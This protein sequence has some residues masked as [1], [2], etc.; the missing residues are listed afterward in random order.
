MEALIDVIEDLKL[1]RKPINDREMFKGA[2]MMTEIS[3]HMAV[4]G[5]RRR[6]HLLPAVQR[7]PLNFY[8]VTQNLEEPEIGSRLTPDE[9]AQA[10]GRKA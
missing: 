10:S 9:G 2:T 1:G 4:S 7:H 5:P 6:L 3:L 8:L